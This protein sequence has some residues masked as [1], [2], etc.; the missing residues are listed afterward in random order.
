VRKVSG[1]FTSLVSGEGLV[2]EFS[3]TGNVYLQT[4]S[5]QAF[6]DWLVPRL[7]TA[8]A[9]SGGRGNIGGILG[10]VLGGR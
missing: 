6:L 7:P 1:I 5:N 2:A 8:H 9:S 4:R 3:G 10:N